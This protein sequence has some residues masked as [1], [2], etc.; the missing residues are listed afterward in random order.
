M[1]VERSGNVVQPL[2]NLVETLWRWPILAPNNFAVSGNLP[3]PA[4]G[5]RPR[6]DLARLGPRPQAPPDP[7]YSAPKPL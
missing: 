2:T 1:R 6:D 3:T 5:C 4:R 7:S